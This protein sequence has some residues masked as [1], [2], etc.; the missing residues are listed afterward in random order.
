MT[1]YINGPLYNVA[2][3]FSPA[4]SSASSWGPS[5]APSSPRMDDKWPAPPLAND[6]QRAK[7]L[8]AADESRT[9]LERIADREDERH[10]AAPGPEALAA[11]RASD[12]RGARARVRRGHDVSGPRRRPQ[13]LDSDARG[14]RAR[15]LRGRAAV[16][17][18]PG[19]RRARRTAPLGRAAAR[20]PHRYSKAVIFYRRG[21]FN[22]A[23]CEY[24]SKSLF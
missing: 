24:G 14:P 11:A 9:F 19:R 10:H 1:A 16:C 18:A 13:A 17:R 20:R 5:S 7:L 12:A 15:V 2:P 22:F 3:P 4:P 8:R 21:K 23:T 6:Q